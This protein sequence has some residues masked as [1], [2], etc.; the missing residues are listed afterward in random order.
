MSNNVV[1]LSK[2][3]S[4]NL[5]KEVP[6]L[7]KVNVGLG[8]DAVEKNQPSEKKGLL[9]KI[10]GT[11]QKIATPDVDVDA[12]ACLLGDSD[13]LLNTV[14]Y[15]N[16]NDA[17]NGVSLSGD[18]LTGNGAASGAD[19]EVIYIDLD[20]VKQ[21]V[22]K[23]DIWAN[24]YQAKSRGQSFGM[25]N[26]A[27]VRLVNRDNDA[28]VCKYNLSSGEYGPYTAVKMGSLFRNN[29]SWEFKADGEG[30]YADT[31]SDIRQRYP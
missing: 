26:N 7:K 27:F 10:L 28:E 24:I 4:I 14:F 3:H 25:V 21:N 13:K 12:I 2:G 17:M 30:T 1:T 29:G 6:G 5:G 22:K 15:G 18:D 11:A 9:G 19:N 23:I 31:L 16:L 8:W 20:T